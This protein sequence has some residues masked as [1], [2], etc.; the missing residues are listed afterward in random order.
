MRLFL[1]STGFESDIVS[2]YFKSNF[3]PKDPKDL[4]FLIISIQDNESDAFYLEKTKS[5][6]K[7]IGVVNIE[8]FK[9]KEGTFIGKKEYDVVYVC[10]G[11]TFD[12]L[13]RIR[14]T[15][16]DKFIIDSVRSEKSIYVGVSAGSIIAGPN[17][18]IAG[19]GSEGDEN[20]VNLK[21]LKGLGLTNISIFPHFKENLKKEVGDFKEKV[22]YPVIALTDEE[23]VFVNDSQ[24]QII[25]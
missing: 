15:G 4:S 9:L 14:K 2:R 17:I 21:D 19:C 11:N 13:D 5:E 10:G 18:E 6:L 12:Y 20:N 16:L 23:A 22:D 25:K 7:K 3:L 8:I 24:Y 1:T